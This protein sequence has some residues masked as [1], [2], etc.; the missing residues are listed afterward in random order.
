MKHVICFS[1]GHS[2]SIVAIEVAR[3]FGAENVILLNH[4]I[5]ASRECEDVK[6]FKQE[7]ADYLNLPITYA[8]HKKWDEM[9]PVQVCVDAGAWKVGSGSILC[10]NRL[11]TAPFDE[12]LK[13]NDPEGENVYYYGFDKDEMHRVQR[14][15][16]IMG[17]R[18]YKT[19]YPIALRRD[20]T[21]ESVKEIGIEP[22][23]QYQQFK[24]GNCFGCLK[25]GFQHWTSFI[26]N[27]LK[28]GKKRKMVK[29]KLVMQSTKT[30]MVQCISKKKKN[31]LNQ[32]DLLA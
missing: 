6:R 22:P 23:M 10:T 29:M 1:G 31:Y 27:T 19:D 26:A 25:A 9:T 3:K 17:Q 5:I 20:R 16:G 4:D 11:K 24:H 2:S 7:V 28:S 14:R 8:N 32:C 13:A 12:W 21:I 18:G 15:S 30:R